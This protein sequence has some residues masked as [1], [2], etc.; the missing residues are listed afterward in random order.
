MSYIFKQVGFH[1][2][3]TGDRCAEEIDCDIRDL[4][5]EAL[6]S[7]ITNR[8]RFPIFYPLIHEIHSMLE[9]EKYAQR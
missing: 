9:A 5:G 4:V 7:H 1:S 3:F 6:R 8:M 2:N